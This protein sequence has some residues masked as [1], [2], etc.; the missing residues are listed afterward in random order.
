MKWLQNIEI[1]KIS[2][3][4]IQKICSLATRTSSERIR[5]SCV[6][7]IPEEYWLG[8]IINHIQKSCEINTVVTPTII[9]KDNVTCVMQIQ[10]GYVKSNI[11]KHIALKF[12]YPY[13]LQKKGEVKI[14]QMKSCENL[15]D[16]FTKSLPATTFRKCVQG[17]GMRRLRELQNSGGETPEC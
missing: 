13:E 3:R 5:Q 7:H 17:I 6:A 14:L 4:H 15:A 16:L 1:Q 2:V 11:T 9:H 8:R 12:F 10:M